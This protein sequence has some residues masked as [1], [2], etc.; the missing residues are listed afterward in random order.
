MAKRFTDTN[1]YK[2]PFIRSLPGAYKLLWDFLYHDCDH[3]GIWIVDFETA[4]I[5]VGK[6][7]KVNCKE[8][9]KLFNSDET[10]IVIL[11]GGKRW[12]LPS[13]IDFQ[14]GKL[15]D[16]NRAHVSV[17]SI[18]NK[19]GVLD[20]F[21]NLKEN[22]PLTSPLQG[23]MD[24]DKD[25]DMEQEKDK[26][27]P[28]EIVFPFESA[29]FLEAWINWKTYRKQS[30]KPY[31]SQLSEQAALKKLSNYPEE[32]AIKMI[33]ESIANSWQGIFELK[34]QTIKNG[35]NTNSAAITAGGGYAG[36]L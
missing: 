2:K 11:D 36:K 31:K 16:K 4:Q 24:M 27:N 25:M 30:G 23:A 35:K 7:M 19:H 34:T 3:A 10:R 18:L 21:F 17:I 33:E 8:A 6:D 1:K 9:L 5:F 12:F 20:E 29:Q 28:K 14:Y 13:F 26:D 15:S 32:V 22:K